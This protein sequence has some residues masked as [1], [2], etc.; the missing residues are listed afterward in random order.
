MGRAVRPMVQAQSRRHGAEAPKEQIQAGRASAIARAAADRAQER[1]SSVRCHAGG[2]RY[3]SGE[4]SNAAEREAGTFSVRQCVPSDAIGQAP[5]SS[6]GK[7]SR[8]GSASSR[9]RA[10]PSIEGTSNIWLR[11]LSAAPHV[12]R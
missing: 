7:P 3:H 10:N 12:K 6:S 9:P 4:T 2:K 5:M 8:L 1:E 11:Q